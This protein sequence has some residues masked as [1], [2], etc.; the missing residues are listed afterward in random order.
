[1]IRQMLMN[2]TEHPSL[3]RAASSALPLV[4]DEQVVRDGN[5]SILKNMIG[6]AAM[7]KMHIQNRT[8]T[9]SQIT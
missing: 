2:A 1:M 7:A 8:S 6:P 4:L 9:D 3:N 5:R